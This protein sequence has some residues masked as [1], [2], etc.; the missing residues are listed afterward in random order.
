[1]GKGRDIKKDAKKQSTKSLKE[2]RIA[3]KAKKAAK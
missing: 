1:M 2:K 3:K